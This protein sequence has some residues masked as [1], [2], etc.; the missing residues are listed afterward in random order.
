MTESRIKELEA[1]ERQRDELLKEEP[2]NALW[3]AAEK[4]D[5]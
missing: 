5:E 4:K 1:A 2:F 3:R